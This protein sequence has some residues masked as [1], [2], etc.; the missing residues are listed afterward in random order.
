MSMPSYADPPFACP[1]AT[2]TPAPIVHVIDLPCP[3]SV[4][5]IWRASKAGKCRVSTSPEFRDWVERADALIMSHGGMRGRKTIYGQFTALI[6][7]KR[8]SATSDIDNRIKAVLDYA[9]RCGFVENDKR[10]IEV[11]ARWSDDALCGCRLT[12]REVA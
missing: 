2:N 4:N 3:P 8:P 12:L 1:P 7:V 6:E 9:Q 5:R 11:T 10:L